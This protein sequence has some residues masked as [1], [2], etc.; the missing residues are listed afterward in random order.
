MRSLANFW[1]RWCVQ[2]GDVGTK[3]RPKVNTSVSTEDSW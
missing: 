2:A 3:L 1:T